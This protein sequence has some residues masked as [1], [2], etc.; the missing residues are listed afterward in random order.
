MTYDK[1]N[2]KKYAEIL[3]E[4]YSLD[5]LPVAIKFVDSVDEI[6]EGIEKLDEKTRH[7]QMVKSASNG[8]TFYAGS[9]EQMCKGGS[10]AIGLEDAP[11]K[12]ASGEKYFELGRFKSLESAKKTLD[13]IPKVSPK[14][15]AIIYGPYEDA[16]YVPDVVVYFAK[17][18][19]GML[20]AQ[21]FV[22]SD[23]EKFKPSFAGIQSLCADVVAGPY[24]N[25]KANIS[26][27]CDGSR[28]AA[29]VK[30]EEL[31]V[32][33]NIENMDDVITT[34]EKIF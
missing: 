1:A 19:A 2:N 28:K 23:G 11:A 17:P 25:K 14:K 21:T 7:C 13:E 8:N 4:K 6:P 15:A 26:L 33:I 20:T 27:G 31:V 5:S 32:G 24:M 22:Y 18:R 29:K 16:D 3:K 12:V 34:I 30:D 9:D 10:S